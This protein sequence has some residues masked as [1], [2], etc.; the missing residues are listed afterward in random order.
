MRE[1]LPYKGVG[2]LP[3][4]ERPVCNQ[5]GKELRPRF[6]THYDKNSYPDGSPGFYQKAAYRYFA[7]EYGLANKFCG[8]NHAADWALPRVKP[9]QELRKAKAER[10]GVCGAR[11]ANVLPGVCSRSEEAS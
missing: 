4:G 1:K 11:H 9:V 5:C 8:V 7:N 2:P 3:V 6:R 10:C